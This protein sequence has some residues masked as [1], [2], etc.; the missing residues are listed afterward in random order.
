MN[1]IP[2]S[3]RILFGLIA[4]FCSAGASFFLLET[5]AD[6][7]ERRDKDRR[8][9]TTAK[10]SLMRPNPA[11]T[12]SHRHRPNIDTVAVIR[13]H[14]V[15]IRI[16]S[17]GMRWQEVSVAKP[18]RVQ[19]I[20]FFGDSFTFGCWADDIDNTFVGAFARSMNPDRF[21]VLNFGVGGYGLDDIELQLE[22]EAIAFSPDFVLIML[23]TGNDFR[24]TYFGINKYR[25]VAGTAEWDQEV[26]AAKLP[27]FE[28]ESEPFALKP[29]PD[30]SRLRRWLL[31]FATF[32]LLL[33]PLGLD[34]PW[35][36]FRPSTYFT[37]FSYWSQY[38]YPPV[39]QRALEETLATLE[40]MHAFAAEHGARLAI[41][42][43][44]YREQ[45]YAA[46]ET[47]TFFDIELP[48]AY[49]RVF[50]RK[51]NIP[52]LDLLHK[53]RPHVLATHERLYLEGD[54]HFNTKGHLLVARLVREWFI[55]EVS[56]RARP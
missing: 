38:P 52:F 10:L 22:E 49:V 29:A 13:G 56:R 47:G 4:L 26:I 48:Q 37:S 2:R 44:P 53:L 14:S 32:R 16:N 21:E 41:V 39:A 17:H 42:A 33:P 3:R 7:L 27:D 35:V 24:D 6:Y 28:R 12:G 30:P 9:Q 5:F 54:I 1:R 51:K 31:R 55:N 45:V 46:T 34:N 19:R 36:E 15:P 40:R 18:R 23:F 50:A 11:G 43:I 20:A 25:L 8:G